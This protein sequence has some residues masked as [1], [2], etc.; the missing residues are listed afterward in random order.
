MAGDQDSTEVPSDIQGEVDE[1][2][3]GEDDSPMARRRKNFIF[4]IESRAHL[5]LRLQNRFHIADLCRRAW[6]AVVT[7]G[8]LLTKLNEL[9][10]KPKFC[11]TF[12]TV[13]KRARLRLLYGTP[14]RTQFD[15][16][17][18]TGRNQQYFNI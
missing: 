17:L 7:T 11:E 1:P 3:E 16:R 10:S 15:F 4:P 12:K 14:L 2:L 18:V 6:D 8:S 5:R 9:D 13:K